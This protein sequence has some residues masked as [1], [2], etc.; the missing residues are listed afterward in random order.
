MLQQTYYRIH[1][2]KILFCLH[3]YN[4][5]NQLLIIHRALLSFTEHC[6]IAGLFPVAALILIS[7]DNIPTCLQARSWMNKNQAIS[8]F[9]IHQPH[10]KLFKNHLI[11]DVIEEFQESSDDNVN[12][13]D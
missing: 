7:K 2:T 9:S 4:T 12:D 3:L 6:C 8:P 13:L 1:A 11:E 5:K 10:D